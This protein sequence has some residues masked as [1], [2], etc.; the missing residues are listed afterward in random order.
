MSDSI[1]MSPCSEKQILRYRKYL[2]K[3]DYLKE[4]TDYTD[5][6]EPYTDSDCSDCDSTEIK[7]L[8][9][10]LYND[11]VRATKIVRKN[12]YMKRIRY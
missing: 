1:Y 4:C 2:V 9:D 8:N 10:E 6:F 7:R 11:Y 5:F 3:D 12:N